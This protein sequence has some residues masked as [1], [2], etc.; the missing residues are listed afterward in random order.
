MKWK[1]E[2]H[3]SGSMVVKQN[4]AVMGNKAWLYVIGYT[5]NLRY[6]ICSELKEFLNNQSG[7]PSW[8]DDFERVGDDKLES[9]GGTEIIARG[10]VYDANPP[11]LDWRQCE[12]RESK[13]ARKELIDRLEGIKRVKIVEDEQ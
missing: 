9:V 13:I 4:D 5:Q 10:P 2:Q 6:Q 11:A 8:L 1:V 12:D 3:P 7:R